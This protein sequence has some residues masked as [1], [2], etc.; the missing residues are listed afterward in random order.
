MAVYCGWCGEKLGDGKPFPG[1]VESCGAKECNR[2]VREMLQ[3]E[4]DEARERA[5]DDY[6][7]YR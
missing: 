3:Q 4:D 7:R 1:D 6:G 5:A 2:N